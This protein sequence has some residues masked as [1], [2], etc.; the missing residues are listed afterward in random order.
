MILVYPT[1]R[2]KPVPPCVC[3]SVHRSTGLDV[4]GTDYR[5]EQ[6]IVPAA[7][8]SES[9]LLLRVQY[10]QHQFQA[11]TDLNL[12]ATQTLGLGRPGPEG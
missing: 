11:H 8:L 6:A 1:L 4:N 9:Q 3:V 12:W 5:L 7:S 2:R 10:L